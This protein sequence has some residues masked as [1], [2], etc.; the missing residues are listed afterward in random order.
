MKLLNFTII[1]LTICVIIGI[2]I[3]YNFNIDFSFLLAL[4]SILL[5]TLFLIKI[6][7][8]R[9]F[10]QTVWFGLLSFITTT[11]IGILAVTTQNQSNFKDHYTKSY[12]KEIDSIIQ[13]QFRVREVLKPGNYYDKY[14][15]DILKIDNKKVKGLS[16]LNIEKD[17]TIQVL[18]VDDILITK[19]E[20]KELIPPLNPYQF[21]YKNYLKKKHIYHQLFLSNKELFKVS[22]NKH[23]IFGHASLLREFI[24]IKLEKFNFHPDQLAII[25]ALLLGQRQDISSEIYNSYTQAG[26]IHILAVSGLHVGVILMLLNILFRPIE[27]LKNGKVLKTI[28]IIIIL[29]SFAIIAGLS[30]SVVRAVFMFTIVAIAMNFKRPTNIY[31][32]LAISLFFLLLIKPTF[33]FDVGFQ[34]SYLAVFAIVTFHPIISKLWLPSN[35]AFKFIWNIFVVTISAQFG[36]IPISLF[37]FHQFPGLFFISNL[38]IIPF[39]GIILG[40]GILVFV[41]ASINLLPQVLASLFAKTIGKMNTFVAWV[42]DKE[43]F[44]FKHISFDLHHVIISYLFIALALYTYYR[45]SFQSVI[46]LLFS[47]LVCQGFLITM[48]TKSN[49]EFIVFHKSRHTIIGHKQ[50]EKL[51]LYVDKKDSILLSEKLITNYTIG[52][53]VTV[54]KT[55]TIPSV[56]EFHNRKLLVIDSLGIYSVKSFKPDIVLLRNSPKFNL[57]RVIDSLQP[58][59]IICDGSNYKSYQDRWRVTCE[60][61]KIPFHQTSKKGAF[62]FRY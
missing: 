32:T 28:L 59:L 47:I 30:A 36:I 51:A 46:T 8:K 16:L 35:K 25:N 40:L 13:L 33:L 5:I 49:N 22:T 58:H 18:K 57:V 42:A 48:K 55:D 23:T 9:K 15:I 2:L 12:N 14:V 39:L 60:H 26:A 53:D 19:T 21:D 31:N 24:N 54:N 37:Y 20:F 1:K 41:L 3:G 43:A 34:L 4:N 62:L 61:K 56:F 38:V 10:H 50:Q 7:G 52:K 6:F 29:W 45:R 17:S 44:L 27:L 11:L